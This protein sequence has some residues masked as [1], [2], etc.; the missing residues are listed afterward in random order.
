M[1]HPNSIAAGEAF[2]AVMRSDPETKV[3]WERTRARLCA[4]GEAMRQLMSSPEYRAANEAERRQWQELSD[5][6]R[7]NGQWAGDDLEARYFQRPQSIE[8]WEHLARIVEMPDA[9]MKSGN[10]TAREV[11]ACARA[12]ADRQKIKAKLSADSNAPT[13]TKP[14]AAKT[15]TSK[16]A[17]ALASLVDHPDWTDEQ[18][19]Q[20][21]GCHVKSLY[22]WKDYARARELLRRGRGNVPRG[23]KDSETGDVEAWDDDES[24]NDRE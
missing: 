15:S 10:Y 23:S 21:A 19:A 16:K 2:A 5:A 6:I 7:A 13:S 17:R 24:D 8:D 20:A 1:E 9:T 22:R 4:F 18:I 11:F 14:E 12:W 3:A